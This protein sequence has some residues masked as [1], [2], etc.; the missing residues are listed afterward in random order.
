[1]PVR[2]IWV[3]VVDQHG[4]TVCKFGKATHFDKQMQPELTEAWAAASKPMS[5][6]ALAREDLAQKSRLS[7]PPINVF[8]GQKYLQLPG[9]KLRWE[10]VAPF[11]EKLALGLSLVDTSGVVLKD[12][13]NAATLTIDQLRQFV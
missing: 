9:L 1:M 4:R 6:K 10:K 13:G 2:A 12:D 11:L 5:Q 8:D 3:R 7:Q